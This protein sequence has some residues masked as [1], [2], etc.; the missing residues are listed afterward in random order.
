MRVF[1]FVDDGLGSLDG[2]VARRTVQFD[3]RRR[4]GIGFL[5]VSRDQDGFQGVTDDIRR[6][7][8][9]FG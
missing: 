2:I 1:D 6:Y 4:I 8:F 7:A 5:L 3:F 9:L